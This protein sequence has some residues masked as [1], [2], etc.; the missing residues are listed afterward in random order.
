MADTI[1][2][3]YKKIIGRRPII[4]LCALISLLSIPHF[5]SAGTF[6]V[7][8]KSQFDALEADI[9]ATQFLSR[10]TFGPTK[11][12]IDSLSTRIE[13]IGATDA[14]EEWIDNQ[15]ALPFTSHHALALEMI[16]N[17]AWPDPIT[18][19]ISTTNYRYFAWWH[20]ALT[21]PDQLRQRMAWALMQIFVV[22][23]FNGTFN[24]RRLDNSGNPQYLGVSS[25]YDMLGNNA[26]GNYRDL[27]EDVSRHPIMGIFLSHLKNKKA[28]PVA[29][30]Y[31][32]E[33]FGREIQQLMSMGLY[34]VKNN[35]DYQVDKNKDP[36]PSYD[37]DDILTFA[38]IFTGL[39]YYGF[40]ATDLHNPMQMRDEW[41][42]MDAKTLHN[43]T[44][45]PAGQ[46]GDQDLADALDNLTEHQNTGPFIARLLIQRLVKSNPSSRYIGAVASAFANNGAGVR[47][48]MKAVIK[49]IL[50][51]EEA[52]NAYAF[53]LDRKNLTLTVN[54]GGTEHSRL[55]EPVIRLASFLRAF[56]P[57]PQVKDA[58]G[59][60]GPYPYAFPPQY[61]RDD[62]NQWP[63]RSPSVFNFYLPDHVPGGELQ[64]YRPRTRVPNR[65]IYAPEF[66]IM[67]AVAVN[68][69][70]NRFRNDVRD[71]RLDYSIRRYTGVG[72]PPYQNFEY[73]LFLNFQDELALADNP[74]ALVQ[75][76]DLL[77]C[78]G[79]MEDSTRQTL[80]SIIGTE[81]T[82]PEYRAEGAILAALT[83]PDCAV[84]E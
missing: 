31:P 12:E 4:I 84:H 35:G 23:D 56:E 77:L 7:D 45:L 73:D 22:N 52:V 51:N 57:D 17:D 59:D 40:G 61:Y 71:Q 10:A 19:G 9:R 37:N 67:T 76:L 8:N 55:Q 28:D 60:F 1:Q 74:D 2:S 47:G 50:L 5:A 36:I 18:S 38:R 70:A 24:S 80:A 64:T 63:Y 69:I 46:S 44:E 48:D 83:A 43:G 68:R 34:L 33:N 78:R 39:D 72:D 53:T 30:T 42:D 6:T 25:Y 82:N 32:D 81:T 15:L 20:A 66:Q 21:A 65:T 27:L 14:F 54:G 58:N 16:N 3:F 49:E 75:H 41:H 79:M 62:F 29:G 11:S 13:E 26:F